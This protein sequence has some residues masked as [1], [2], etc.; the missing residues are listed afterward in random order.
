M[1]ILMIVIIDRWN[2]ICVLIQLCLAEIHGKKT[3]TFGIYV[4]GAKYV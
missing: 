1:E 3:N 4:A 2:T